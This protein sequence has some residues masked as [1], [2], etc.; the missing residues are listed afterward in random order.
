MGYVSVFLM[1]F[2][3]CIT[4]ILDSDLLLSF[5]IFNPLH[6]FV[7]CEFLKVISSRKTGIKYCYTFVDRKVPTS[8]KTISL[9]LKVIFIFLHVLVFFCFMKFENMIYVC[10]K[11]ILH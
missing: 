11:E 4:Y 10:R 9:I 3:S 5:V 6:L 2:Q 7:N 1:I 8:N